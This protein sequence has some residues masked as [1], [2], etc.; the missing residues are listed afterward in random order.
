MTDFSLIIKSSDG[1]IYRVTETGDAN[2]A[3]VWTGIEVKHVAGDWVAKKNARPS[4]VRK[5]ATR[6]VVAA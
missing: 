5:A 3:H 4:L 2:L 6:I 1:R